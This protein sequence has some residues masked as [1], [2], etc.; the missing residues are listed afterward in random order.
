MISCLRG[1][2]IANQMTKEKSAGSGNLVLPFPL[3]QRGREEDNIS[4]PRVLSDMGLAIPRPTRLLPALAGLGDPRSE[5][6]SESNSVSQC[7][8]RSQT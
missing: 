1:S 8:V 7:A 2:E 6:E 3:Q 5:P 4:N